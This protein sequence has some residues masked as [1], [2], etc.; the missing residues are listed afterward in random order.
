MAQRDVSVENAIIVE[1]VRTVSQ[2]IL[3]LMLRDDAKVNN[4]M[5][6]DT[7]SKRPLSVALE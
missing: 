4:N 5:K 6:T 1:T 7:R 3:I 2:I